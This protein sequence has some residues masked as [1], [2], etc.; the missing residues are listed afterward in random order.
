M[1][2]DTCT[3]CRKPLRDQ[4]WIGMFGGIAQCDRLWC[5]FKTGHLLW[6]KWHRRVAWKRITI[7]IPY[8]VRGGR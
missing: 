3:H 2:D 8:I 1:A 6:M 4:Y 5:R 7:S